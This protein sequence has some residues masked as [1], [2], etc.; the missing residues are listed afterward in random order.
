MPERLFGNSSQLCEIKRYPGNDSLDVFAF[1]YQARQ[2]FKSEC[3]AEPSCART[4]FEAFQSNL[5][6]EGVGT[7]GSLID[8][9][10]ASPN[11]MVIEDSRNYDGQSFVGEVGGTLGL[12]LG[13]SFLSVFDFLFALIGLLRP[14][15]KS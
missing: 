1:T 13:L 5:K 7:N 15:R 2:E 11:V 9:Q 4:I 12:M 8:I 10:L 6:N 14:K 3:S